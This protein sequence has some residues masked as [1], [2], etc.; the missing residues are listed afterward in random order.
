M[1]GPLP[2]RIPSARAKEQPGLRI[3]D[4]SWDDND[5]TNRSGRHYHWIQLD[6]GLLLTC[7]GGHRWVLILMKKA[8]FWIYVI[9]D[10]FDDPVERIG[11]YISID[12]ALIIAESQA[13]LLGVDSLGRL[14][15]AWRSDPPVP[16][17]REKMIHLG[18]APWRG[19]TKGNA[20][21]EIVF[22]RVSRIMQNYFNKK[23]RLGR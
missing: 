7:K 3:S 12:S 5:H 8:C 23:R 20:A 11:R 19:M 6:N 13:R 14:N 21:D 1:T 9:D 15:M 17:Q 18:R 2:R 16:T 10:A 22:S 4:S